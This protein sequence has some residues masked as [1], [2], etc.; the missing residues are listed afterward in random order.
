MGMVAALAG[1]GAAAG[2][3]DGA[4]VIGAAAL[5]P[6]GSATWGARPIIWSRTSWSKETASARTRWTMGRATSDTMSGGVTT[7]SSWAAA[8]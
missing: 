8:G 7:A 2:V 3:A 4:S 5:S 1:T 6:R